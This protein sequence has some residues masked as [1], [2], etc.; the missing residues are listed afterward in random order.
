MSVVS[1]E[2]FELGTKVVSFKDKDAEIWFKAK[3]VA[4]A[5]GYVN[6]RDAIERH[7]WEEYKVTF[8]ETKKGRVSRPFQNG[9]FHPQTVFIKEYGLYQLVVHS[10]LPAARQF[11]P[12][13]EIVISNIADIILS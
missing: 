1:F 9:G 6:H 4:K 12:K 10:R 2:N 13:L 3:D 8:G 7:V 11:Q 5:L